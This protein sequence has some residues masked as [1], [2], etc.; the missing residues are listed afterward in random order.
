[1]KE[2][3]T[4]FSAGYIMFF[5]DFANSVWFSIISYCIWKKI[6]SVVSQENRDQFVFYSTFAYG[7][8]A[9]PLGIIISINQFWEE[10]LRKWNWLPLVGFSRC[11]VDG[12]IRLGKTFNVLI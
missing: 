11:S 6:T 2:K 7:I 4:L 5:F 8:S 10:D 3:L 1:M 12:T 9:I